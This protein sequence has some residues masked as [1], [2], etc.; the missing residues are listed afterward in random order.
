MTYYVKN[1]GNDENDG[2]S[3]QTAWAS[4]GK[5]NS[6]IKGGDTVKF[7][8]GDVF[9][10]SIKAVNNSDEKCP[11]VFEAYG[12]GPK[13]IISQYKIAY[14]SSW[15]PYSENIWRIDLTDVN[16]YQGNTL[17]INT[18]VGFLNIN[19]EIYGMKLFNL[20]K[21]HTQWDF[22]NDDKYIYVFS[23]ENPSV[24]GNIVKI[25]CNICCIMFSDNTVVSGLDIVGSGGHGIRG[26]VENGIVENCDIHELGG[27]FLAGHSIENTRYGNGIEIWSNS[28]NV[29]V[30]NNRLYD[31]Y[32]VAITMQGNKVTFGWEN[33]RFYNNIIWNNEQSFEIWSQGDNPGSGFKN[34]IFES[35]VCINA[36]FGWSHNVR[37][38]RGVPVHILM[39][40]LWCPKNDITVKNNVFYNPR[41][42]LFSKT[43][44]TYEI[45]KEFNSDF[46]HIYLRMQ[47]EIC[48]TGIRITMDRHMDF[49]S[50]YG[51]EKNSKFY[52]IG[53]ENIEIEKLILDLWRVNH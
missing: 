2:L 12:E 38:D 15:E 50:Y 31:I 23:E 33:I 9:Y 19:G 48:V 22:F 49:S 27:S 42:G 28:R 45:P 24:N 25:A 40:E 18:N 46:N 29:T 21:L 37:P 3:E 17:D 4:I 11:T 34:C 53:D 5:V 16:K 39:Y 1:S 32:D 6:N 51:K 30:R 36:G 43:G 8:M 52:E 10:G 47:Q 20:N 44:S 26:S 7:N 35:N 41:G 13:P 14:E